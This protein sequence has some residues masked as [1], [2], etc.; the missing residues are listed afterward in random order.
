MAKVALDLQMANKPAIRNF[1]LIPGKRQL[2]IHPKPYSSVSLLR[3]EKEGVYLV[4][5]NSNLKTHSA[6]RS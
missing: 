2:I 3:K 5:I 6:K 4:T 1:D